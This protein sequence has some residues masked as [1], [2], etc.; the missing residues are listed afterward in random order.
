MKVGIKECIKR[1]AEI[2][3]CTQ[4]EA[5][6][7][8]KAALDA[9]T[10]CILEEGGVSFIGLFS[11]EKKW[12]SSRLGRNPSTGEEIQIPARYTLKFTTGSYLKEAINRKL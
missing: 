8:M 3:G 7:Q 4:A 2:Q 12:A 1:Y 11:I 10:K 5:T 9:I 6:V